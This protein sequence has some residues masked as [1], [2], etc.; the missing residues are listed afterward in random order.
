MFRFNSNAPLY[1]LKHDKNDKNPIYQMLVS[2]AHQWEDIQRQGFDRTAL[3]I[4]EG[5]THIGLT[6]QMGHTT[7][8]SNL[9]ID[10]RDTH[11]CIYITHNQTMSRDFIRNIGKEVINDVFDAESIIR[12]R[13]KFRG[14]TRDRI[15]YIFIDC[16]S[17]LKP[18]E[19]D[20]L[21]AVILNEIVP[22]FDLRH[23]FIVQ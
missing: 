7:A 22:H 9:F 13:Y 21:V 15:N 19:Q 3:N 18:E 14:H 11:G 20:R 12:E 2:S 16:Y 8:L 10:N 23:V 5:I 1:H 6:R 4:S 17:F